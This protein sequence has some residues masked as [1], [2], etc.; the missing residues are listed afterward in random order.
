MRIWTSQSISGKLMRM[1]LLVGGVSL[2]LAYIS[3]LIYDLYSLRQ[4]LM[5]SMAV[6]ANIIGANCV[7]AL[8]FDDKQAAENTLSA[9]R[10]SP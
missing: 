6:E 4:Q 10:N 3:F 7:S 1:T 8:E 2:L 5:T 9:L